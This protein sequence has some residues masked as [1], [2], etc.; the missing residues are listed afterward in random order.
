ML[1]ALGEQ[2]SVHK[3]EAA[4][5]TDDLRIEPWSLRNRQG[6][7]HVGTGPHGIK[8]THIPSGIEACVHIGQ[9]QFANREI[10]AK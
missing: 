3:N 5:N 1:D 4:T 8:V 7:M 10:A 6:G 2:R 9:S